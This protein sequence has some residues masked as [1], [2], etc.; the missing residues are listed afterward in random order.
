VNSPITV[1]AGT[2]QAM[3]ATDVG[4]LQPGARRTY[5]FVA[6]LKPG[7][8]ADNAYQG[9]ALSTGFRWS[10][11][12]LATP[13]STPTPAPTE[14]ATP[15]ATPAPNAPPAPT[16][17]PAD[18]APAPATPIPA[19]DP[20]AADPTGELLGAQL[21]TMPPATKTCV[22]RRAFTIHV[23]RPAG[24]VFTKL[25]V[26]VNGRA[27]LRLKGLKAKKVKAKINLKGLPAGTVVVKIAAVTSTGR[28]AVSTRTYKTCAAKR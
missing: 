26:T 7:G 20:T 9:S 27:K 19:T 5:L 17:V 12:G 15:A 13:T 11:A 25:T 3:A 2:V 21:F 1:Y 16:A 23:R 14:T 8:A 24:M 28:T 22:S 10:A 18:A 6:S 4:S